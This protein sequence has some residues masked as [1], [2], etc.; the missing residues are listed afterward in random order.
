MQLIQSNSRAFYFSF[1]SDSIAWN[2]L[3]VNGRWVHDLMIPWYW[4]SQEKFQNSKA[5]STYHQTCV[6]FETVFFSKMVRDLANFLFSGIFVFCSLSQNDFHC[7]IIFDDRYMEVVKI[8]LKFS[9]FV[10]GPTSKTQFFSLNFL[11][12][13]NHCLPSLLRFFHHSFTHLL[14]HFLK[15]FL[16]FLQSSLKLIASNP[17]LIA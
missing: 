8:V 17:H 11:G 16:S 2:A 13:G 7:T 3:R 12:D 14:S 4:T 15:L 5:K 6:S 1:Y 10:S 9:T